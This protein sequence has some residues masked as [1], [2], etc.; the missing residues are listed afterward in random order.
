MRE[1]YKLETPVFP[2]FLEPYIPLIESFI[3]RQHMKAT[4]QRKLA[5]AQHLILA[6]Y[7]ESASLEQLY[8]DLKSLDQ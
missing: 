5:F 8:L 4:P 7:M 6:F 3:A 2:M 1:F